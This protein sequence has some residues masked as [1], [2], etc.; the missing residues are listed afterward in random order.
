MYSNYIPRRFEKPRDLVDTCG[1]WSEP[2]KG[3]TAGRWL[4]VRF[5]WQ[6][7]SVILK[8]RRLQHPSIH[9]LIGQ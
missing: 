6:M 4:V 7:F 1:T 9:P 2:I 3:L 8:F 5:G